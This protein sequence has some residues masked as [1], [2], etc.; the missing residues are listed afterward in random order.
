MRTVILSSI[1]VITLNS[2]ITP[3]VLWQGTR[4][5][6]VLYVGRRTQ[7]VNIMPLVVQHC[8]FEGTN[9]IS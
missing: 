3:F 9:K 5:R 7:I 6:V 8:T 4:E 1:C 2:P